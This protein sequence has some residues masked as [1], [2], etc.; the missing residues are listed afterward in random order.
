MEFLIYKDYQQQ[1]PYDEDDI[2]RMLQSGAL[3]KDDLVFYEGLDDWEPL[4]SVFVIQEAFANFENDGQDEDAMFDTYN[5]ACDVCSPGETIYYIALQNKR[6]SKSR[7]DGL[8]ATDRRLIMIR[9][10]LAST[11]LSDFLWSDISSIKMRDTKGGSAISFLHSVEGK[12]EVEDIPREQV[13]KLFQVGQELR[14][15]SRDDGKTL[16]L[17]AEQVELEGPGD[18]REALPG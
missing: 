4:E 12:V 6:F 7:P 2:L 18:F 10:K 11:E 3:D 16:M 13:V 15:H 14:Q 1:G 9:H 5:R 8:I 17:T